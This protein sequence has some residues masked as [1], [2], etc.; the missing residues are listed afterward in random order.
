M[1]VGVAFSPASEQEIPKDSFCTESSPAVLDTENNNNNSK[2]ES[3]IADTTSNK[4]NSSLDA[5]LD[6]D[7]KPKENNTSSSITPVGTGKAE[8]IDLTTITA[9][10]NKPF[11]IIN[12]NIPNF[13]AKELELKAYENYSNL[14]SLGRCRTAI[15][16]CGKEIMPRENEE[17][18]SI[19]SIKPTGWVQAKYSGV[20]GGYLYNRCH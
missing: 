14:D 3:A 12:D 15:A 16:V 5:H 6:T 9:Y 11:T 19:S 13:S 20:S 17:R 2:T 10:S 8:S 1:F 18:G 4:N 7:S